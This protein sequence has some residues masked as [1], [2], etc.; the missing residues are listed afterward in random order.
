MIK[1]TIVITGCAGFLGSHLARHY[2]K[3]GHSVVGLDNLSTGSQ[4]NLDDLAQIASQHRV[5]FCYLPLDCAKPWAA[6]FEREFAS[7]KL[8]PIGGV[9]HFASPASPPLYQA[10]A[11]ETIWVNTVGLSE[12]LAVADAHRTQVLF[13]ST[14]EIYGDPEQHPQSEDYWGNVNSVGLRSCYD[15][16]K[17]LGETIVFTHNLKFQTR[18][19]IVRIFNT[20]G[21]NMNPSDGRVVINFLTQAIRGEA[22]TIYGTGQQTRSFCFVTDLVEG[23]VKLM[24]HPTFCGPVNLGN[25][26]EFSMLE[27]VA[28]IEKLFSGQKLQKQFL[29]LPKDDP[30]Q[31]R[32]N[33]QLAAQQ[34]G[35]TPKVSLAEGLKVM[36]ESLR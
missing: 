31:R 22:L 12:A 5:K 14:S 35:W 8:A 19:K 28:E 33:I 4:S 1:T 3:L 9:Y 25:P 10:L 11:L 15:E 26:T 32:P 17:R 36:L 34:L 13:A 6:I 2:L 29:R 30:R 18:H 20:Y 21:P 24:D 23:L 16:S 27:L 7:L